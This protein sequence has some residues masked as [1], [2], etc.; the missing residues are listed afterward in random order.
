MAQASDWITIEFGETEEC[1]FAKH[2]Q[3][4]ANKKR[5]PRMLLERLAREVQEYCAMTIEEEVLPDGTSETRERMVTPPSALP[6]DWRK[7]Q[8]AI[9]N[10]TRAKKGL[11]KIRPCKRLDQAAQKY[12][13]LMTKTGWYS[14][15]GPNGST[16]VT[17]M[18][19]QGYKGRMYA[20]NIAQRQTSVPNVM[21]AWISSDG[22]Y[23]NLMNRG[24]TD[25]GF[26]ASRSRSGDIFWV[27]NFGAGG[28]CK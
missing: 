28:S 17:R 26:G 16:I 4:T 23:R 1:A 2:A 8:L 20:E 12:A 11:P 15:T 6:S 13:K 22:H 10:A 19:Q 14:H 9:V 25:V 3:K 24:L 21:E 7:Q 5:S 18:N 27:Q